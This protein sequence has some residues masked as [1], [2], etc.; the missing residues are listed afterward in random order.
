MT[1]VIAIYEEIKSS[2]GNIRAMD[3]VN[4]DLGEHVRMNLLFNE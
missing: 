3:V 1:T 2:V 4:I